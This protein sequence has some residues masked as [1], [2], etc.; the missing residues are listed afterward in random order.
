MYKIIQRVRNSNFG[1]TALFR[2][3][4]T[5]WMTHSLILLL[6]HPTLCYITHMYTGIQRIRNSN[7]GSVA[8]ANAGRLTHSYLTSSSLVVSLF[9][10]INYVPCAVIPDINTHVYDHGTYSESKF[11]SCRLR[12]SLAQHSHHSLGRLIQSYHIVDSIVVV[13]PIHIIAE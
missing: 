8:F 10:A 2:N 3:L 4:T 6:T 12:H 5:P 13:T 1:S 7:L 11:G 9:T